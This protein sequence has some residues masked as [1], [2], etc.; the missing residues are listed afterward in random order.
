MVPRLCS[1]LGMTSL[2]LRQIGHVKKGFSEQRKSPWA[3]G[4]TPSLAALLAKQ[5][6]LLPIAM[7]ILSWKIQESPTQF[8]WCDFFWF[9]SCW[10]DAVSPMYVWRKLL[11]LHFLCGFVFGGYFFQILLW[12]STKN[13]SLRNHH[14]AFPTVRFPRKKPPGWR[15]ICTLKKS[16]AGCLRKVDVLLMAWDLQPKDIKLG[17]WEYQVQEIYVFWRF[18]VIFGKF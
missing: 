17:K 16:T 18:V 13:H 9:L 1:W 2:Q 14:L 4:G 8:G 3:N 15:N 6:N 7:Q 11:F 10:R 5:K 12:K